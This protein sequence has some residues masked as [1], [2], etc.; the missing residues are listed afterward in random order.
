[1]AIRLVVFFAKAVRCGWNVIRWPKV[2]PRYV[3]S[4]WN[5]SGSCL[6]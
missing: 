4:G 1:M 5:I 6:K 3:D 2:T